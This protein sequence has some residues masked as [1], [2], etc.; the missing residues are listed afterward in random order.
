MA[1][2][3]LIEEAYRLPLVPPSAGGARQDHARCCR[4]SSCSAP[5][6]ACDRPRARRRGSSSDA[7]LERG[8]VDPVSLA[9]SLIDIDS[10]TGREG[11]AGAWLARFLA[12][13]RLSGRRSSRSS[14]GRFNVFASARR[15]PRVVFST[16]FDCVPPF[17]PSREERG[18]LFGRGCVRREGHSRRAG[19]GRRAAARARR[20]AR[21]AAVRRRRGA[22]QRRRAGGQRACAG[23]RAVSGQRR[24]DR[25]P[26]RR[27]HA[28]RAARAAA[29][30]KDA[31][32]TRR[33][34]SSASRRSTSCS[35]R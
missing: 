19:R 1:A 22:R 18:L 30:A 34:R 4:I 33:F 28:R 32:R 2:M 10:T 23:W 5:P 14:D 21:R 6:P 3:G 16:H 12:R 24:A 11:E 15:A 35:T 31:R 17:F 26:A 8:S 25:Q 27:R 13:S 7:E 9:R 29:R 20:D